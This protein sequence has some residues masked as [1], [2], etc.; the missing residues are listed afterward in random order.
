MSSIEH[1]H[2]TVVS[3][4]IWIPDHMEVTVIV[5]LLYNLNS[6]G[7]KVYW[8]VCSTSDKKNTGQNVGHSHGVL[9]KTFHS[10]ACHVKVKGKVC[11]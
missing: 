3:D 6:I 11:V 7:S 5:C 9:D 1:S 8:L 10:H 4:I 2:K